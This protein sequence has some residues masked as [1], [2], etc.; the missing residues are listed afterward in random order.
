MKRYCVLDL[1]IATIVIATILVAVFT[2]RVWLPRLGAAYLIAYRGMPDATYQVVNSI[3]LP[4]G[5]IVFVE[6][7]KD[8]V[9]EVIWLFHMEHG[10]VVRVVTHGGG[11]AP[12]L[13]RTMPIIQSFME[14]PQRSRVHRIEIYASSLFL[15]NLFTNRDGEIIGY[16]VV[17]KD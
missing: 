3:A 10:K 6:C 1:T 12:P 14:N 9:G 4:G 11:I 5:A 16:C 8:S 13:N 17:Y 15:Y 2:S 7:Q